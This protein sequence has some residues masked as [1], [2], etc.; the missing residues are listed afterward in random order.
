MT[1]LFTPRPMNMLGRIVS[2]VG[3][4]IGLD[5]RGEPLSVYGVT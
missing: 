5:F 1:V 2:P 3:L 4:W